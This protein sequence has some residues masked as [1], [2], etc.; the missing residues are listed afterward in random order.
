LQPAAR[1]YHLDWLG[2]RKAGFSNAGRKLAA[3]AGTIRGHRA[4]HARLGTH[5]RQ[6]H[7]VRRFA[8]TSG[9][10]GLSAPC[11]YDDMDKRVGYDAGL[12]ELRGLLEVETAA[13]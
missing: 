10:A 9:R 5:D 11:F 13:L 6:R 7:A 4:R 1:E 2:Q 12:R 3:S 8:S